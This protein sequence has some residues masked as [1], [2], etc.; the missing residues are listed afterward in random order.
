MKSDSTRLAGRGGSLGDVTGSRSSG[1][2][3]GARLITGGVI[4][5]WGMGSISSSERAINSH[6]LMSNMVA[7]IQI[8]A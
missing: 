1:R 3:G 6:K 4:S 2:L 8:K 7:I 5:S